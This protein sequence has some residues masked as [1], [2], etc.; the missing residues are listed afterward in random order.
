MSLIRLT[1]PACARL[2]E[3]DAA[4]IG[5]DV[6]CGACL[7]VFVAKDPEGSF[8]KSSSV[9]KPASSK[10][11]DKAKRKTRKRRHEEDDDDY[12]FDRPSRRGRRYYDQKSR[13]AYILLG[14]FLGVWGV[15][16]FYAG[17]TGPGIAQLLITLL[18][19]PL[20]FVCVGFFTIFIPWIWAIV[21]IIVV[22]RDANDVPMVP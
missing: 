16:N 13:L 9:S 14:L 3:V 2:L 12:E 18:S 19:I 5:T 7:E 4:T 10:S 17:R 6:E 8:G 22:D 21:D 20:M 1:C 15:H 11:D